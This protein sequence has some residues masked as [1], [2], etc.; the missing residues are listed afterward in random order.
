MIENTFDNDD[1][2]IQ[3]MYKDDS[4]IQQ[5]ERDL[6]D[7]E[8]L[9][10]HLPFYQELVRRRIIQSTPDGIPREVMNL[11]MVLDGIRDRAYSIEEAIALLDKYGD[12]NNLGFA[13]SPQEKK[14]A[15]IEMLLADEEI[16]ATVQ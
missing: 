7:K 8:E 9:E 6:L 16:M 10:E 1:E 3:E 13:E 2:R 15:F 4:I 11:Q 12:F 14:I 5:D